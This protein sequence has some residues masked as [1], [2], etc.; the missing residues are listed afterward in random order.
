MKMESPWTPIR[1]VVT[2]AGGLAITGTRRFG[3]PVSWS[4]WILFICLILLGIDLFR[5]PKAEWLD[6]MKIGHED[7]PT[8]LNLSGPNR[9]GD[10]K[11]SN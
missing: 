1:L 9:D 6:D 11:S 8:T 2:I 5:R 4:Y 7:P 10:D 3:F